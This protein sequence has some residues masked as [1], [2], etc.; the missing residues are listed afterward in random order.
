MKVDLEGKTAV[1]TGASRGI[2]REIVVALANEGAHVAALGRTAP[3]LDVTVRLADGQGGKV[4]AHVC[5]V[6]Q[7]D[8]VDEAVGRVA[9]ELGSVDVVVNNAGQRQDFS[10][11]HELALKE[12]RYLIDANLTSVFLMSK[13]AAQLMV[14]NGSGS[15]VN[16][17]SI[18]GPVA[19][20]RIGAYCAAKSGV[21]ALTKVMAAELAEFG[22]TVNAVAPGWIESSMNVE[23]RTQPK[24]REAL[25][26]IVS[27]TLLG[28]FGSPSD[29]AAAVVFLAGS[30]GSYVTGE[31]LFVDG[32]WVAV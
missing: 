15:I 30:T 3:D 27:R 8:Q 26:S 31:T 21:I 7:E 29:V 32:G 5:D 2:G 6:T 11:L 1:V 24:N 18:A 13:T 4:L 12:W 17:A 22:I 25:E 28:R 16:I 9:D 14:R 10:P 20:A 19:F 23:L